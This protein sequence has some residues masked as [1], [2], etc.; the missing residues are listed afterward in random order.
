MRQ[1][2]FAV[3]K[4]HRPT[5]DKLNGEAAGHPA[6]IHTL[7]QSHGLVGQAEKKPDDAAAFLVR[8]SNDEDGI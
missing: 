2:F 4:P 8:Q 1:F 7:D 3:G 5:D 6:G